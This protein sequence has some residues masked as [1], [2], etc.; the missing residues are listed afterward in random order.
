[1]SIVNETLQPKID[2]IVKDNRRLVIQIETCHAMI[3]G[4]EQKLNDN[5]DDLRNLYNAMEKEPSIF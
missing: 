5:K 4:Y 1:M 2:Q 3:E